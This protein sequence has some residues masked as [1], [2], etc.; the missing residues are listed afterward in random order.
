VLQNASIILNGLENKAKYGTG[1]G[2]VGTAM[3]TMQ[4]D[5]MKKRDPKVVSKIGEKNP[6]ETN[7]V[8]FY[9]KTHARSK[10]K[11]GFDNRRRRIY[12]F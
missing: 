6:K 2:Y 9:N 3:E 1:Y 5:I 4:M 8:I 7:K 10:K 12:R 11:Y